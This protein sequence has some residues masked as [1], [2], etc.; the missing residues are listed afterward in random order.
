MLNRSIM[1][2]EQKPWWK[3]SCGI[4][5]YADKLV[6]GINGVETVYD[7]ERGNAMVVAVTPSA[8]RDHIMVSGANNFFFVVFGKVLAD[9]APNGSEFYLDDGSGKKIKVIAQN[10]VI[11]GEYW[12]AQGTLEWNSDVQRYDLLSSPFDISPLN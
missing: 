3:E 11:P 2:W 9:P 12:R 7:F 5:A 8:V 4:D 10:A 1:A 6:I